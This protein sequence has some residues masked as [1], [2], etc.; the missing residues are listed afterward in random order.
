MS[1]FVDT[2][3][4]SSKF[5][6]M[7]YSFDSGLF[8]IYTTRQ[9]GFGGGNYYDSDVLNGDYYTL[10]GF[11]LFQCTLMYSHLNLDDIRY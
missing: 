10:L 7:S 8:L 2:S 6:A 11:S 9:Q 4:R 1:V 5:F 3:V